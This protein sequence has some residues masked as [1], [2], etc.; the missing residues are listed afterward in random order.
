MSLTSYLN[1]VLTRLFTTSSWRSKMMVC[2]ANISLAL[3]VSWSHLTYLGRISSSN[4]LSFMFILKA[5][6][7][8][9]RLARSTFFTLSSSSGISVVQYS[10][11]VLCGQLSALPISFS[12]YKFSF[13]KSMS[14][15]FVSSFT[16]WNLPSMGS[17]ASSIP[18]SM[19]SM[20]SALKATS[21]NF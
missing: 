12:L 3:A 13:A 18:F 17:I 11:S 20:T 6:F 16:A 7:L 14:C 8:T 5:L 9:S 19:S 1:E 4:L 15:Y 21:V 10:R 2:S